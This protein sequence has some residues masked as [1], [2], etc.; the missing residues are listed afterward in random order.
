M[1]T[2]SCLSHIKR[3]NNVRPPAPPLI[4]DIEFVIDR[5]GS[6]YTMR[7]ETETGTRDFV[8]SQKEMANTTGIKTHIRIQ[9]FDYTVETMPGFDGVDITQT[10]DIDINCL[11]PRGT[12]RL[13]DTACESLYAQDRRYH[14]YLNKLPNMVKKLHPNIIRIFALITDGI[15]NESTLFSSKDLNRLIKKYKKQGVTCL[16]LGA[17]QDAIRQGH[18]FGF[19]SGH[20][21]TYSSQGETATNAL[22][23]VSH[24]IT[25][26]CSGNSSTQFNDLQRTSS[27]PV[28]NSYQDTS[29]I[30]TS[31]RLQRC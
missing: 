2:L 1:T 4:A 9:T 18:I 17:N 26:A 8:N 13:V 5:S 12:T 15:D 16:F 29:S 23:A 3:I 30:Y 28:K 22:R 7:Q 14:N 27:A 31:S 20:S 11:V 19:D 25:R 10:N 6:M 21:L 24:Q